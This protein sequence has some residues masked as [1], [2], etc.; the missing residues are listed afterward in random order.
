MP[1]PSR[2]AY[3]VIYDISLQDALKFASTSGWTGIVPD[4]GVPRFSPER[5]SKKERSN[6][7]D[8]SE[9]YFALWLSNQLARNGGF[10]FLFF[11]RFNSYSYFNES[12]GFFMAAFMD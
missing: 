11:I 2:R 10:D 6:L 7:R 4:M 1:G 3:H 5:F 8:L 12:T 9:S